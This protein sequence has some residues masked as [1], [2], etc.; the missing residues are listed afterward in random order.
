LYKLNR[1]LAG[2]KIVHQTGEATCEATQTLYRKLAIDATVLPFIHDLSCQLSQADLIVCRAGGTTLAELAAKAVP[3]VLIPF[4]AAKDDHQRKN[5]LVYAE[6]GAA[7]IV[8]E[9]PAPSRLD[10]ALAEP[11]ESL[12]TD[13]GR[14]Q[15]MSSAMARLS[16]PYAA[17]D[18]AE[19]VWSLVCSR[20]WRAKLEM[21]A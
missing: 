6:A 1:S 3:A 21:A 15:E 5:A 9:P 18:V 13:A 16:R 8:E 2:W 12:L 11:L 14:R 7:A 10:D 4:P 17:E 19:L 20:S